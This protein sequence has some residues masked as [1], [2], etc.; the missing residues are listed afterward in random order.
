VK[1]KDYGTAEREFRAAVGVANLPD[2]WADLGAFY[3]ERGEDDK[4]V[5]ALKQCL[6]VDHAKDA[7]VVDAASL[8]D[9]MHREQG[10]AEQALQ[11]YLESGTKS[12]AAPVIE[13][14]VMLGKLLA[15]EGNKAGAKIEFD[16]ALEMASGYAP[17]RQALHTL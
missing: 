10:L 12:D 15:S 5:D 11:G 16:K 17:A 3:M 13:V 9:R 6:A 8:L 14:H 4:A 1:A 7:S 2:A